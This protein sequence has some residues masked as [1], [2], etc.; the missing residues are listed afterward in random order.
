MQVVGLGLSCDAVVTEADQSALASQVT[1]RPPL[2]W[3]WFI[4]RDQRTNPKFTR[5]TI[6]IL[7]DNEATMQGQ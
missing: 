6:G 3:I 7:A 4:G 1:T 2:R 5:A